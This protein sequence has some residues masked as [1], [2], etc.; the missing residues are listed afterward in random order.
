MKN[1]PA[2]SGDARDADSILGSEDALEEKM[3]ICS[4]ILAWRIPWTVMEGYSFGVSKSWTQLST[5]M[6]DAL[7]NTLL[8]PSPDSTVSVDLDWDPGM[9]IFRRPHVY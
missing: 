2:N 7:K 3:G 6:C 9:Y 1:P 4:S 8:Y 5:H